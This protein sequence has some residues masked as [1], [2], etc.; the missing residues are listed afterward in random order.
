MFVIAGSF[1]LESQHS[2]I[3]LIIYDVAVLIQPIRPRFEVAFSL[4]LPTTTAVCFLDLKF[5]FMHL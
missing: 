1:F 4:S 2:V 3:S 5:H